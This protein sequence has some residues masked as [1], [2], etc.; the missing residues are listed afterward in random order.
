MRKRSF[1]SSI[2]LFFFSFLPSPAVVLLLRAKKE[3]SVCFDSG[4]FLVS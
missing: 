4:A 1:I 2:F 3:E